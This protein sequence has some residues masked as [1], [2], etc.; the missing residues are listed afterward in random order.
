MVARRCL[1]ATYES[2]ASAVPE[3]KFEEKYG[4]RLVLGPEDMSFCN[5]AGGF[6]LGAPDA[7]RAVREL[8][9]K[10][11]ERPALV[12]YSITG[13]QPETIPAV[14]E[15]EGFR[16]KHQLVQMAL[17]PTPIEPEA[18]LKEAP[19]MILRR[20]IAMFMSTQF[21]S[22]SPREYR[23]KISQATAASN[24]RIFAYGHL[25]APAG[26]VMTSESEESLGIF[27]LCVREGIRGE[28]LGT[29]MV[30]TLQAEAAEKGLP[31]ILQCEAGLTNWYERLGFE[32]IG[33]VRWY[34]FDPFL[35]R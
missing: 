26:A 29:R 13:D 11:I 22:S 10:S 20:S 5:C 4:W 30:K 23:R 19:N 32:K 33:I 1:L 27:N 34:R 14:L 15:E 16:T 6:D 25:H 12:V 17:R 7:R 21:F 3:T 31:I 2:L 35:R 24:H 8:A 18:D 9:L 28:G